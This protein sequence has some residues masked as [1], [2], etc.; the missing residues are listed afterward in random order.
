MQFQSER[1]FNWIFSRDIHSVKELSR[2]ILA[3]DLWDA[4]ADLAPELIASKEEGCWENS[5]RDTAR[6]ASTLA[7]RG[8]IYPDVIEWLLSKQKDGAWNDDVYD[9]AYV[10]ASLADMGVHNREACSWLMENYG[11]AWEHPG[12]T[13]LIISALVKQER[14][15]K[16]ESHDFEDFIVKRSEW[17]LSKRV[18]NGAWK[19]LATSN[20]VMQGLILAGY[21]SELEEALCWLLE[22]MNNNGSW[23]KD[24]GDVN[25]TALTLIT[26]ASLERIG[27]QHPSV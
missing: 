20:I 14:V 10:L 24:E 21:G 13:A 4:G 23:G 27:F 7:A 11:P 26:L 18:D 6:A 16:K 19:T 8:I 3:C 5:L 1:T 15:N 12:T 2:V 17:I 22:R 25:T 9:T